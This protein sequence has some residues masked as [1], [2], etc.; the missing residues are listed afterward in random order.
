MFNFDLIT[1]S[2]MLTMFIFILL[3]TQTLLVC[4]EV[5]MTLNEMYA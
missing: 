5:F 3:N 1:L 2:L 4:K